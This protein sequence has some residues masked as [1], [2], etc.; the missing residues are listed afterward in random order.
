M[1][2]DLASADA[3]LTTTRAVRKRL[4]FSRPVARE[5]VLECVRIS[6]QAPTGG[7]S[8]SWRWIIVDDADKRKEVAKLFQ[9]A[10]GTRFTEASNAA[11]AAGNDQSARVYAGAQYLVDRFHEVPIHAIACL[12]GAFPPEFAAMAGSSIYPAVWSFQLA[13]RARGLGSTLTTGL[14]MV[15]QEEKTR[16]L[17]IPDDVTVYALLPVAYTIG[18]DFKPAARPPAESIVHWNGW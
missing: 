8:Q 7:N 18:T 16:V 15:S 17:G 2:I 6:Q 14:G 13:L 4:D 11:K 3:L 10:I 1:T 12:E 9:D 5:T